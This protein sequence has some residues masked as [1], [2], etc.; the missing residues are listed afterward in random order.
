MPRKMTRHAIYGSQVSHSTILSARAN[1][2]R[3]VGELGPR[4]SSS[5]AK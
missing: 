2:H 1:H 5:A 3:M 4:T